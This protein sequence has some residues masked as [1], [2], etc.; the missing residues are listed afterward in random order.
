MCSRTG[1]R[2]AAG[3]YQGSERLVRS[4]EH[5]REAKAEWSGSALSVLST[6]G[7]LASPCVST[8]QTH[9]PSSAGGIGV[10]LR[11]EECE[12]DVARPSR[13]RLPFADHRQVAEPGAR[14]VGTA[15]RV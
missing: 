7:E 10:A 6:L 4:G 2:R 3:S 9:P 8:D 14:S 12:N 1:P 13:H 15:G 11:N 5:N